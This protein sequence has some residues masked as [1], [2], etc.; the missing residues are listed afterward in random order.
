MARL[1]ACPGACHDAARMSQRV[2]RCARRVV[3]LFDGFGAFLTAAAALAGI[4][5]VIVLLGRALRHT[6]FA[7]PMRAARTLTVT[8]TLALDS[9]RRL[10]LIRHGGKSVL[11]LTG[12]ENDVVVG[13]IDAEPPV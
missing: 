13:W 1:G 11:L 12:G 5:G 3:T 2:N 10:H 7:R 4:I 8:E 6:S 9:R